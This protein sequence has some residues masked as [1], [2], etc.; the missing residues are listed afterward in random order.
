MV[1]FLNQG[2]SAS[3]GWYLY[4]A[5][6][7]EVVLLAWGLEAF[8]SARIVFPAL[9]VAFAALDLYGTHAL[10]MPYYAGLTSHV[11]KWV[12]AALGSALAHVTLVF[13]SAQSATPAWLG[14]PVMWDA[15]LAYVVATLGTMLG[16][17][18]LF[19]QAT[20]SA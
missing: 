4:A 17:F 15:W 16:V 12:P 10:L 6:G 5:V 9:A 20:R 18:A 2:I 11:G 8:L 19:R 1:I 14:V 3:A 7:A 13:S